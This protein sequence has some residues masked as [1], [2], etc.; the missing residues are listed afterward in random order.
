MYQECTRQSSL[1]SS[2][3]YQIIA[4]NLKVLMFKELLLLSSPSLKKAGGEQAQAK[5]FSFSLT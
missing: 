2:T 1:T 3:K 4:F 5:C